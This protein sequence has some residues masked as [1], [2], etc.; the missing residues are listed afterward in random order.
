MRVIT[1]QGR[2]DAPVANRLLADL[3]LLRGQRRVELELS[4]VTYMDA[5]CF[6]VMMQLIRL[7]WTRN[8]EVVLRSPSPPVWEKLREGQLLE[9]VKTE[10]K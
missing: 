1:W 8:G 9:V 6:G 3:A 4:G 10:V 7:V 5:A 2:L